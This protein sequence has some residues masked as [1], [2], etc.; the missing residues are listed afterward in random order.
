MPIE[1]HPHKVQHMGRC[2]LYCGGELWEHI[3]CLGE[4]NPVTIVH[5][6]C[7]VRHQCLLLYSQHYMHTSGSE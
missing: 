7:L 6:V 3:P 1:T 4:R 5:P 2:G